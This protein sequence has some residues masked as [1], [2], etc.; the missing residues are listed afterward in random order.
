[1]ASGCSTRHGRDMQKTI[2]ARPLDEIIDDI[3]LELGDADAMLDGA[4]G[5]YLRLPMA[6]TRTRVVSA[7]EESLAFFRMW[8]GSRRAESKRAKN[9]HKLAGH[10][11]QAQRLLAASPELLWTFPMQSFASV[12]EKSADDHMAAA[13]A[14]HAELER[15]RSICE[16]QRAPS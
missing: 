14:F 15:L 1:L 9:A 11:R 5:Q 8:N 10:L 13:K 4:C 16:Q 2:P 12:I 6:E 3:M 7:V